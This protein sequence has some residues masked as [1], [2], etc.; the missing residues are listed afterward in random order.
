MKMFFSLSQYPG[1][2]GE[3]FY[4]RMFSK[5]GMPCV[6]KALPCNDIMTCVTD[7]KNA[8]AAG[9]SISMPFK[10][11]VID[12][13]D[14]KHEYVVEYNSCNS[15]KL[16]DGKLYGHNT[17]IYGVLYEIA[18]IPHELNSA[19]ILGDGSMGSMFKKV[20]QEAAV[21][22]SR[23]NNNWD[24]R[25]VPADVIINCTSFG[26]S[27]PESPF[28]E[29]PKCKL[30]IDLA[31]NENQ[32]KQQANVA[33]VKYMGGLDFYKRQFIKQFEFYTGTLLNI[34]DLEND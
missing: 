13:L 30:V 19:S 2:T 10:S 6:Y 5:L 18:S 33:G 29:L 1:K 21:V 27:T 9:I 11:T 22:Y 15:I 7:L 32:L 12:M 31:I 14:Y 16:I 3:T 24:K 34:E 8:G 28:S 4:N 25:Y 17:D 23:K 26:T 20:I